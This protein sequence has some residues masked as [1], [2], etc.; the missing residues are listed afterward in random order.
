[1]NAKSFIQ[2]L[3]ESNTSVA[4]DTAKTVGVDFQK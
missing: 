2:V 1:M 4:E 3:S